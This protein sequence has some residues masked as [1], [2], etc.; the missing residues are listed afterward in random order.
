MAIGPIANPIEMGLA[1]DEA[2]KRLQHEL[3]AKLAALTAAMLADEY[4]AFLSDF[5]D[6]DRIR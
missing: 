1:I 2:V 6:S 4:R 5:L 3:K